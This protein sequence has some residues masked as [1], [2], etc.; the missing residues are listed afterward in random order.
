MQNKTMEIAYSPVSETNK[1]KQQIEVKQ[2]TKPY[3]CCVRISINSEDVPSL[4][5]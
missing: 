1:Q 2:K 5:S 4:S 3:V